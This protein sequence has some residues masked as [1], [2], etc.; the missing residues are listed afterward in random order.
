MLSTTI[1]TKIAILSDDREI[2]I[3]N[4]QYDTIKADQMIGKFSDP[5]VIRDP[6]TK[7]ILFDGKIWAIREFR[8]IKRNENAWNM[9][10]CDYATRHTIH[11]SCNCQEKYWIYPVEF[12]MKMHEMFPLKYAS[13]L[14]NEE[15][16]Q[17]IK[18]IVIS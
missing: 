14:T 13:T 2:A 12:R 5:I 8:D 16:N 18:N 10:V 6:D 15:K 9:Y 1:R 3:T 17:I 4:K 11:E 7:E